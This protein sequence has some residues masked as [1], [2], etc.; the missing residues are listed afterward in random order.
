MLVDMRRLKS[1]VRDVPVWKPTVV[2]AGVCALAALLSFAHGTAGAASTVMWQ[3]LMQQGARHEEDVE[4][5]AAEHSFADALKEADQTTIGER[6]LAFFKL[7]DMLNIEGK[8]AQSESTCRELA[9]A[10]PC[11][12]SNMVLSSILDKEGKVEEAAKLRETNPLMSVQEFNQTM[13]DF[14]KAVQG[15]VKKTWAPPRRMMSSAPVVVFCL[16]GK[17][18]PT[19]AFI[20]HSSEDVAQDHAALRAIRES[21]FEIPSTINTPCAVDFTFAYNV[22]NSRYPEP[23]APEDLVSQR[24]H[25]A[26]IKRRLEWQEQTLGPNHPEVAISLAAAAGVLNKT[27]S[28]TNASAV[29]KAYRRAVEIWSENKIVTNS[30]YA[31]YRDLGNFLV[32]HQRYAEAEPVLRKALEMGKVFYPADSSEITSVGNRLSNTLLQLG[33]SGERSK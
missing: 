22:H 24:H 18:E 23:K 20:N 6:L 9:A 7:N 13:A 11:R 17:P 12:S 10:I 4:Y 25:Y 8:Y 5:E 16:S 21:S 27:A 15:T 1:I 32:K 33:K 31:C 19:A 29:E 2:N 3:N 14:R 28:E 26:L 30:T